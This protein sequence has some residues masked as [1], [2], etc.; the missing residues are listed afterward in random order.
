[1]TTKLTHSYHKIGTNW[2]FLGGNW[3]NYKNNS[4][5]V[6]DFFFFEG[7][8][9]WEYLFEYFVGLFLWKYHPI[10]SSN[11]WSLFLWPKTSL[12][13]IFTDCALMWNKQTYVFPLQ[14]KTFKNIYQKIPTSDGYE[15][16][17]TFWKYHWLTQKSSVDDS[18]RINY[19]A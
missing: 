13:G 2:P 16:R 19:A 3:Q 11:L 6:I 7:N 9:W 17:V 14:N 12:M 4:T 1:M 10:I 8:F 18:I 15:S 5:C